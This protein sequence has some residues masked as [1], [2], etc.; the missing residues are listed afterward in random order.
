VAADPATRARAARRGTL[1]LLLAGVPGIL[2]LRLVLPDAPGVP[3][4]ALLLQP[5]L[6][7]ALSTFA[8][9]RLAARAGL[10][11]AAGSSA[12]DR[13]SEVATGAVLGFA[14]GATDHVGR[15]L[16]QV[17]PGLPP[18]IVEAWSANGLVVGLLYGGVVE[19]VMFRWFATSLLAVLLARV[20]AQRGVPLPRW[21]M[22]AAVIGAAA[23]FAA[24][25]LPAL[26]LTGVPPAVGAVVRTLLL[27]GIAGLVFG[28][29]FARRDFVAA[30][31]AHGGAHLG[32]AAA[33]IVVDG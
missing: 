26:A 25:H 32:F 31:L 33:V 28:L 11:L 20:V 30:M 29:L 1:V 12:V 13:V 17:A 6:L 8:G 24:S 27:N 21:V 5:A 22:P 18:S 9:S 3:A 7:L 16:W 23:L 14:I 19:E 4:A 10:R 2:S 15:G